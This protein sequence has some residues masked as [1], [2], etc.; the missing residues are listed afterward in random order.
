MMIFLEQVRHV[1]TKKLLGL[2]I[3]IVACFSAAISLADIDDEDADSSYI[4]PSLEESENASAVN[5]SQD[6]SKSKETKADDEASKELFVE[7]PEKIITPQEAKRTCERL[8]GK[9]IGYYGEVFFV[10]GNCQRQKID[11]SSNVFSIEAKTRPIIDV[12]GDDI[13]ALPLQEENKKQPVNVKALCQRVKGKYITVL[14]GNIYL[15]QS[16]NL[17]VCVKRQFPDNAALEAHRGNPET[18][19]QPIPLSEEEF[20]AMADG[21]PMPQATYQKEFQDLLDADIT[22]VIPIGEACRG[23]VD[24][25]IVTSLD[26]IY[27][28][29]FFKPKD[30]TK[31]CEKQL[32]DAEK[33]SQTHPLKRLRELTSKQA[34]SIPDTLPPEPSRKK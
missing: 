10:T 21:D 8:K 24:K 7:G 34:I 25:E 17:G 6:T 11:T 23:L 19:N 31:A 20:F 1:V 4:P 30:G 9:R 12:S 3:A 18:Y 28:I 16:N 22:D 26:K 5:D 14:G 29:H 33:I 27:K 13:Q 15:A 32:L 2:F